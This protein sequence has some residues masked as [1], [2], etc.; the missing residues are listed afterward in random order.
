MWACADFTIGYSGEF[1]ERLLDVY[2]R[3]GEMVVHE[4]RN[5]FKFLLCGEG[6]EYTEAPLSGNRSSKDLTRPIRKV[7]TK[8]VNTSTNHF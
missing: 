8:S 1:L 3:E 7:F 4:V 2:K 6:L 5:D